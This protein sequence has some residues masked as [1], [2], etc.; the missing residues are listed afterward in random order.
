MGRPLFSQSFETP[1]VRIEPEQP[2]SACEKW[3]YWNAFDPDSDEFFEND[4]AV[5]EAFVDASQLR[6]QEESQG[7]TRQHRIVDIVAEDPALSEGSSSGRGSPASD[8][9]VEEIDLALRRRAGWAQTNQADENIPGLGLD[10]FLPPHPDSIERTRSYE[11]GDVISQYA[12]MFHLL[13]SPTSTLAVRGRV[14]PPP[15]PSAPAT[16]APSSRPDHYESLSGALD[17]PDNITTSVDTERSDMRGMPASQPS[18]PIRP[19]TPPSGTYSLVASPSTP[20][21]QT[22]P[23][24]AS[25]SPAPTVTPRLYSWSSR[26]PMTAYP[27]SPVLPGPLPNRNARLSVAHIPPSPALVSVHHVVG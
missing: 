3:T 7:E 11:P 24:H 21:N 26:N 10:V 16:S 5:Y 23:L 27:T 17:A 20:P 15:S 18:I 19:S 14:L 25:P 13:S 1:A 8:M 6:M 2:H 12:N 9:S 4:N 22:S